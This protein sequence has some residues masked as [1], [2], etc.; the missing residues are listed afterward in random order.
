[1]DTMTRDDAGR[2]SAEDVGESAFSFVGGALALDLVNTEDITRGRR[3]GPRAAPRAGRAAAHW[4]QAAR[5]HHPDHAGVVADDAGRADD[6]TLRD[7][8]VGLRGVLRRT[9]D[10]LATGGIPGDA[11]L[12]ALNAVLAEGYQ[13]VA[14]A[15]DGDP[16]VVWHT[17]DGRV[18]V[19]LLPIAL[20][21]LGLMTDGDRGRLHKCANDRCVLLF[22]DA[23]KSATRRWCSVGCKDRDR[24][25][26]GYRRMAEEASLRSSIATARDAPG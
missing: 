14:R 23:T 15:P 21:A 16:R 5:R 12:D 13:A 20:S 25:M 2:R 9:F 11:D 19:V 18:G 22:Y 10:A 26:K 4:W 6:R 7:A 17:R 1:M 24:K 3:R 8:L